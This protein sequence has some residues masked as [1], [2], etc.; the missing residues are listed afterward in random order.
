MTAR[1]TAGLL[2]PFPSLWRTRLVT[3]ALL[4]PTNLVG[5]VVVYVL[6]TLV[7][8]V[9]VVRDEARA[10]VGNLIVAGIYVP[11]A[12]LVGAWRGSRLI[13]SANLWL[14]ERREPTADEQ[15]YLLKV[16]GRM[17]WLEARLWVVGALLFAAFNL[18]EGM[19]LSLIVGGVVGLTGLTVASISYLFTE[20]SLRPLARRALATGVPERLRT[21]SVAFRSVQ[22]WIFGTGVAVAGVVFAGILSF[23]IEDVSKLRLQVTMIVLGGTALL[24]GALTTFLAAKA[25]SDPVRALRRAMA[26]LRRGD[27]NTKVAIYDGTEVGILQAGFNELVAGLR[28]RE[29][30]RDLFGRHVGEDVARAALEGGVR[31]GGE[32]RE[33]TILFVDV[34][35][36]T[37]LAVERPPEEVVAVLN[38]F[39][40]VVI[41]VVH[42]HDGFINKFEGDAAL[43]IWGA[44]VDIADRDRRALCAARTMARRLAVEVPELTAGIGVSGGPAVAGN[45]GAAARYEY[46]VIGDPVNEAARLTDVAKSVPGHVVAHAGLLDGAGSETENW[47]RLEPVTVRGR[48]SPTPI[49]TPLVGGRP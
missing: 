9:P 7:V 4:I 33:V 28:E 46:T 31:L 47:E 2:A 21:R 22:A 13:R 49:A 35:G 37:T 17:F 43:A 23:A 6:L 45:V 48:T 16:P 5:A 27:L 42:E 3:S 24:V 8:P 11:F 20:R 36:S 26:D 32:V 14:R 25:T 19:P 29:Q 30:I 18:P 41:D 12:V 44:P 10:E 1:S 15:R 39:F 40:G 38:R 34:V